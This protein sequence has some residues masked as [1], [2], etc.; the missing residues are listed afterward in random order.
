L[1]SPLFSLLGFP[2]SGGADALLAQIR[3]VNLKV[4]KKIINANS[5]A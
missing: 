4:E 2:S 1:V 3:S 5:Q